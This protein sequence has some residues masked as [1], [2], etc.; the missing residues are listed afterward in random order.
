MS[1][2]FILICLGIGLIAGFCAGLLG[3]GGGLIIVPL[4]FYLFEQSLRM[5]KELL[6]VATGTSLAIIFVTSLIAVFTHHQKKAYL[7]TRPLKLLLGGVFG[8]YLG[9]WLVHWLPTLWVVGAFSLFLLA[10]AWQLMQPKP[11]LDDGPCLSEPKLVITGIIAGLVGALFGLGGGIVIV[12]MLYFYRVPMTQAIALS[13]L[14]TCVIALTGVGQAVWIGRHF[15]LQFSL[16]YVYLPACFMVLATSM[17][18]APVGVKLAH[19]LPAEKLR[20]VFAF[21]L[22]VVSFRMAYQVLVI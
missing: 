6:E 21:F 16:G 2:L 8:A 14:T 10:V 3:V 19:Q 7:H 1:L 20:P 17:I 22:V 9:R 5:E 18:M 15:D 13:A 11:E 12:P 4:F